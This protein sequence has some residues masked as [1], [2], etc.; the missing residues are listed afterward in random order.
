MYLCRYSPLGSDQAVVLDYYRWKGNN[1]CLFTSCTQ[2]CICLKIVFKWKNKPQVYK[3]YIYI[4]NREMEDKPRK[5]KAEKERD[6]KKFIS[7]IKTFLL[8]ELRNSFTRDKGS[9]SSGNV[10]NVREPMLPSS[11]MHGSR[12]LLFLTSSTIVDFIS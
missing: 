11:V 2:C 9:L 5:T 7:F 8:L 6:T 10:V 12:W 1:V 3:I 4:Y